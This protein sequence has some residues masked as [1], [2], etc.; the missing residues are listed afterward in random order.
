[1]QHVLPVTAVRGVAKKVTN[2]KEKLHV[3]K[4]YYKDELWTVP[5][6]ITYIRM[7]CSPVL[8]WAIVHDYKSAALAGCAIAAFSDWLD[9][10]IAKN[11]NQMT[12]LGGM[13][14]PAAGTCV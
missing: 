3:Y 7:F 11:Y 5:N 10:Y 2:I 9:G 14:D 6:I 4:D 12:V 13:I 1:V 8:G